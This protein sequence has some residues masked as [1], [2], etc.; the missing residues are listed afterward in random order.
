MPFAHGESHHLAPSLLATVEHLLLEIGSEHQ[1]LQRRILLVGLLDA[2]QE[3]GTDNATF[4][5]RSGRDVADVQIPVV[6][7]ARPSE[8]HLDP[9]A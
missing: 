3:L 5:A 2:V 6:L 1:I 7:L 8:K 9:W 4:R